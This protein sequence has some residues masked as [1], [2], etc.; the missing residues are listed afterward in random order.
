MLLKCLLYCM[1]WTYWHLTKKNYFFYVC[2][3]VQWHGWCLTIQLVAE[4]ISL[5]VLVS[6]NCTHIDNN[7]SGTMI[8]HKYIQ[9]NRKYQ[10]DSSGESVN[11][12]SQN[13]LHLWM[14][15]YSCC[16]GVIR[17][18]NSSITFPN[19]ESISLSHPVHSSKKS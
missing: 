18:N 10:K 4:L 7:C 17:K 5:P 8:L 9:Q 13:I 15:H 6:I 12:F 2:V 16:H 3:C 19:V 14:E 1:K 11:F